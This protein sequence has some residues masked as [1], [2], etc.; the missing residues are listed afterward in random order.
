MRTSLNSQLMTRSPD[1]CEPASASGTEVDFEYLNWLYFPRIRRAQQPRPSMTKSYHALATK[2]TEEL[3]IILAYVLE[4]VAA[5]GSYRIT[6]SPLLRS[7]WLVC[8]C[9]PTS[10][11]EGARLCDASLT[12]LPTCHSREDR[13]S[14]GMSLFKTMSTSASKTVQSAA[15][16]EATLAQ[17]RNA[18]RCSRKYCQ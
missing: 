11:R 4:H 10:A 12:S 1:T 17:V 6:E 8:C 3:K 16:S 14:R 9:C 18:C 5:S 15:A 13:K 7:L 2:T